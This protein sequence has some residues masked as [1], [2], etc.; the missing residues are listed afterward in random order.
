MA[1]GFDT[2]IKAFRKIR[3]AKTTM[4][5]EY[6]DKVGTLDE[7]GAVILSTVHNMLLETGT[8]SAKTSE[9]TAF[10]TTKDFVGMDDVEK[11][12]EFMS[13]ECAGGDVELAAKIYND[14]PWHFFTKALS[15]DAVKNYMKGDGNGAP[16]P[17]VTYDSSVEVQIRK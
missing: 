10:L 2:L 9:G 11:F 13:A 7:Q 6:K 15:K 17:G 1:T 4:T 14:F 16:P 5:R 8:D 12:R 3:D